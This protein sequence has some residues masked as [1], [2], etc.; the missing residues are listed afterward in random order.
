MIIG[1]FV[2]LLSILSCNIENIERIKHFLGLS[3]I[4][5]IAIPSAAF[6]EQ[7][8][9]INTFSLDVSD[10]FEILFFG[11]VT[12]VDDIIER[13]SVATLIRLL[14]HTGDFLFHTG[15]ETLGIEE[16]SEPESLGS[17]GIV[18]FK[19]LL[20]SVQETHIPSS[21]CG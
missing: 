1:S 3:V 6:Q 2:L 15:Q 21:E 18:P 17:V 16:S 20:I 5:S 19:E 8:M 10:V 7:A 11:H 13:P 9:N 4:E 14:M 12:L